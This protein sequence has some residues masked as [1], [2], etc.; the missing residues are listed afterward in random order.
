MAGS[1]KYDKFSGIARDRLDQIKYSLLRHEKNPGDRE[2]INDI[3]RS[4]KAIRSA[5]MPVGLGK[6]SELCFHLGSALDIIRRNRRECKLRFSLEQDR[7]RTAVQRDS[8]LAAAA[9]RTAGS[10]SVE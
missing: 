6:V 1:T 5:A 8:T 4:V 3:S 7:D 9:S 2:F 10:R